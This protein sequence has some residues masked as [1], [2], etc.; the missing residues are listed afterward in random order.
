MSK[1][2]RRAILAYMQYLKE[3][4]FEYVERVKTPVDIHAQKDGVDYYFEIKKTCQTKK[5]FGAAT[6]TE[7]AKAVDD[8]SKFKF[9]VVLESEEKGKEN[10]FHFIEYSLDDFRTFC[11]IPPFKIYFNI[12]M[13]TALKIPYELKK[14]VISDSHY[15]KEAH[16]DEKNNKM[17]LNIKDDIIDKMF[18][19]IHKKFDCYR[20]I[21]NSSDNES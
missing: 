5:Y 2:D 10:N 8:P 17:S 1:S 19:D 3:K 6:E 13:E 18:L 20:E 16:P 15:K 12:E 21:E 9:V 7:W 14:E 4:G 11:S